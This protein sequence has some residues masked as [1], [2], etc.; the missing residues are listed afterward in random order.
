MA[1]ALMLY[2]PEFLQIEEEW[3]EMLLKAE[4]HVKNKEGHN[5]LMQLL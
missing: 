2:Q 3:V 4:L 5:Y 1:A